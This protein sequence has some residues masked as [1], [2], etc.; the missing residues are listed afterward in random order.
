MRATEEIEKRHRE[1]PLGPAG[2][3][4]AGVFAGL[5]PLVNPEL[6]AMRQSGALVVG[7]VSDPSPNAR[8][9]HFPDGSHVIVIYSGLIDFYE[10]VS[11]ILF[12]ASNVDHD[13]KITKAAS[14]INDV[15]ANLKTLF[16]AWTP[17]GI[18][19][20][21]IAQISQTPLSPD[22]AEMAAMLAKAALTFV[23]SHEFGHVQYY[24]PPKGKKPA[25]RL[26]TQQETEADAAGARNLLTAAAPEGRGPARMSIAGA[27]VSLRVLA[28]LAD[29]G[30]TFGEGHPPPVQRIKT[31]I[32]AIRGIC[33]PE[34]EF[35]SLSTIAFAS[36]EHLAVAGAM[37]TGTDR[38]CTFEHAFSRL[39]SILETI[40]KGRKPASELLLGMRVDFEKLPPDSL[41]L[42]AGAAALVF[43]AAPA[44]TDD[45]RQDQLWAA[46]GTLLRDSIASFPEPARTA[47]QAA[48]SHSDVQKG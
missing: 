47:F 1:D 23:L 2:D 29:L 17:E 18:A 11:K 9:L 32:R 42:L 30:H 27:V 43:P 14:S 31:V 3:R 4:I 13:G 26:S 8:T 39:V 19:Q 38:P 21:R 5:V 35:W 22:P 46:M 40:V 36:D 37:A 15:V 25:V 45:A 24:K 48:L 44:K 33:S 7:E 28:V 34:R 10:S 41:M 20:D 6:E 12:G 16:E